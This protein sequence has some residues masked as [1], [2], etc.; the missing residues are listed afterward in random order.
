MTCMYSYRSDLLHFEQEQALGRRLSQPNTTKDYEQARQT[1]ILANLRL[2]STVARKYQSDAFGFDDLM[3]EGSIGLIQAV[4]RFEYRLGLRFSTYALWWI[5]QAI[6]RAMAERG[7]LIRV[8]APV[9]ADLRR[10]QQAR[11][12]LSDRLGRTPTR[13]ELI[14]AVGMTEQKVSL[15]LSTAMLPTSLDAPVGQEPDT[16]VADLIPAPDGSDP[17]QLATSQDTRQVL[18]QAVQTLSEQ[19]QELLIARFGLNGEEPHTL[20]ELS[21][22][23]HRSRERLRQMELKALQ[24]LRRQ[25]CLRS[26]APGASLFD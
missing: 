20:E 18:I 2:V 16:R 10:L 11:Q 21:V 24:K 4:D 14:H 23:L 22:I 17:L 3:Q 26:L 13:E 8:P 6:L 12:Q 5:K 7:R 15:L 25:A 1:L 9:H 19:E